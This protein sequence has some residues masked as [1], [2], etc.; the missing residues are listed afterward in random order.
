MQQY[1][2]QRGQTSDGLMEQE[3]Q[4]RIQICNKIGGQKGQNVDG[5]MEQEVQKFKG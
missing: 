1:R 4:K 5:F 3:V 2:G